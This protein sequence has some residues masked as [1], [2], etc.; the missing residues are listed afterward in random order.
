MVAAEAVDAAVEEGGTPSLG[1][2]GGGE[3]Q[4]TPPPLGDVGVDGEGIPRRRPRRT[5][6]GDLEAG[7]DG[8]GEPTEGDLH[9][10]HH[11]DPPTLLQLLLLP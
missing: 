2:Q 5:A 1:E 7:E 6:V 4:E 8:A 3:E 10:H 9:H 11:G